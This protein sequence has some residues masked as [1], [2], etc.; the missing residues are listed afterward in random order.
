MTYRLLVRVDCMD[1]KTGGKDTAVHKDDGPEVQILVHSL[2]K[3]RMV[4]VCL[5]MGKTSLLTLGGKLRHWAVSDFY[6]YNPPNC[7]K[8]LTR[9][10]GAVD[11]MV[12]CK[13]NA[14]P[15]FGLFEATHSSVVLTI[16]RT[17]FPLSR[18]SRFHGMSLH[19]DLSFQT[20]KLFRFL[21]YFLCKLLRALPC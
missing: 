8:L 2:T 12:N 3:S 7:K 5:L 11:E 14:T 18:S 6:S 1:A 10:L 13:S 19:L 20:G 16:A 21:R 4:G 17:C 9:L 15:L